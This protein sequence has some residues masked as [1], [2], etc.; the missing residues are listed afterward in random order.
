MTLWSALTVLCGLAT[1]YWQLLFARI[2]VGIGEAGGTP[3]ASSIIS[4][5]FPAG[6]PARWR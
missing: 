3:A 1:N 4:D 5:Y 6:A 2:G